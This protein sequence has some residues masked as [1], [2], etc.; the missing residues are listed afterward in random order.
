[1]GLGLS[2]HYRI[3]FADILPMPPL[4]FLLSRGLWVFP[5]LLWALKYISRVQRSPFLYGTFLSTQF[6]LLIMK[7]PFGKLA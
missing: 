1:M 3:Y 5:G 4:D 6:L 2:D 7:K